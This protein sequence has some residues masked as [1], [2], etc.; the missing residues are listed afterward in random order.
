MGLYSRLGFLFKPIWCS[1]FFLFF[2]APD[3]DEELE[4]ESDWIFSKFTTKT[5][6]TQE[7]TM[8]DQE[9]ANWLRNRD[10]TTEKIRNALEHIRQ[11]NFEPPYINFY[12]KEY[13]QPELQINDLW[14]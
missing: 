3:N 2:S 1:N 7:S 5:I 4:K 9:I 13:V 14:R 11:R 6:S 10:S 12:C 8:R